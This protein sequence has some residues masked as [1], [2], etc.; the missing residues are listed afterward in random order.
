MH[1][2]HTDRQAAWSTSLWTAALLIVHLLNT[3]HQREGFSLIIIILSFK[4]IELE[5]L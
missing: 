2:E 1:R 3:N 5:L 4:D